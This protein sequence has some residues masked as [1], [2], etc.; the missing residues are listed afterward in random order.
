MKKSKYIEDGINGLGTAEVDTN[1]KEF[2][3]LQK[4]IQ[5]RA[6]KQ[7]DEQLLAN[8]KLS[9]RFQKESQGDSHPKQK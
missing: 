1:S 4:A 7:S 5:E 6:A 9:L 8:K 3:A 2:K